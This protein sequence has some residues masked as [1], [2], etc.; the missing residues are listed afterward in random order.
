MAMQFPERHQNHTLEQKS[1]GYF[2]NILPKEWN[3]TSPA[4]DYGQDLNI[5]LSEDGQFKGLDL[6]VQLKASHNSNALNDNERVTLKLST[7]NYLRQNLRVVMIVKFIEDENEA[8]W[9]LLRDVRPPNND[10]Q[11]E[12]TM[13]F[14]R[15]NRL[16][17]INWPEIV[18]YIRDIT[19]RKLGA[20]N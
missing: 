19:N 20:I 4:K 8:Y 1:E 6:I 3:V 15:Q 18:T 12:F 17:Q 2:R 7:Y 10:G 14:P 13:Y 16:S 9:T 11:E 5:E